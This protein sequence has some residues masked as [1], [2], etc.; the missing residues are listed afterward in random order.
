MTRPMMFTC[1][2]IALVCTYALN[3]QQARAA[4]L[5]MFDSPTCKWC[6]RWHR[7][8][9]VY[10]NKTDESKLAP[11]KIVQISSPRPDDLQFIENIRYTPTFV[12]IEGQHE[13]GRITGYPGEDHFWGLLNTLLGSLPNSS[14][15]TEEE[16]RQ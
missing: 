11:L 3:G 7:E 5:I 14:T 4:E 8:V 9:G 16:E 2:F 15:T 6:K 13:I 1:A 10:F 12:L